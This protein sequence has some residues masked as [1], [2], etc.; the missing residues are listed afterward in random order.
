MGPV[1]HDRSLILSPPPL[2]RLLL[3][4]TLIGFYRLFFNAISPRHTASQERVENAMRFLDFVYEQVAANTHDGQVWLVQG[5]RL[6][7]L[8]YGYMTSVF[9]KRHQPSGD[10]EG[11]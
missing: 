5:S 1:C 4:F 3:L 6:T 8:R 9:S 7:A 11:P 2:G 10:P